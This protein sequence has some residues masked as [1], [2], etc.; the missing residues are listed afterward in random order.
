MDYKTKEYYRNEIKLISEE[1]KISELYIAK[2]I[3]EIAESKENKKERH[4]GYYL[5]S[6][7]R[8]E[9]NNKLGV[10][11][12]KTIQEEQ[13]SRRYIVS[14]FFLT[15][16]LSIITAFFIYL[17]TK[18]IIGTIISFTVLYI[19]I[20]EIV[21]QI[22]N[23]ILNK[24]VKPKLIPKLDFEHGVPK[25]YSTFVVIPTIVNSKEKVQ[26]LMKKIEVYY[27]ANKSENLYFALLGDCTS[28]QKEVEKT[29]E[30]IIRVGIEEVNK[31]NKKYNS[32]FENE[33]P[34]FNFLYRKRVWNENEGC[35]LGWERKRGLLCEF[36]DFLINGND[37][38]R[39]NTIVGADAHGCPYKNIKYV[40]TLDSD[41][42][43]TLDSGVNL[44]GTMAHVLNEPILDEENRV[45]EDGH[46]LIQPRVG[47]N[48]ED[49][50]KSFFAKI[51]S[52]MR[53]NRF[54]YKCYIRYIPR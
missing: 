41:T 48:L 21:I 39:T 7:G 3:L 19:P 40:I 22:I 9:L 14:I 36:N 44:I 25:E 49:S 17:G 47:I 5:I 54:I 53:R 37:K 35:Y 45:V 6:K 31:L 12:K 30:E 15:S 32:N 8:E 51:Y 10:K 28:G 26:E 24:K 34:K 46:A 16:L 50:R 1:T 13:K 43:L 33:I 20:S 42:N 18:S 27:L 38:F 2:K 29:D 23:N 52:G 4:I 11:S